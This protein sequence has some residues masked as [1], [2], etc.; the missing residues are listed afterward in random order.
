MDLLFVLAILL[1][2]AL[3]GWLSMPA[4]YSSRSRLLYLATVCSAVLPTLIVVGYQ[5]TLFGLGANSSLDTVTAFVAG[6]CIFLL[7]PMLA[8]L[9]WFSV[10][11]DKT[12]GSISGHIRHDRGVICPGSMSRPSQKR[13]EDKRGNPA[14]TTVAA[15]E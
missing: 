10:R 15:I 5:Y 9:L 14:Q 11:K 1:G 8:A 7:L 6:V 13:L 12:L 4:Y 3:F 2:L